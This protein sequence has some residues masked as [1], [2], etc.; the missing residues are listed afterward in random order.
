MTGRHAAGI[1]VTEAAALM[2]DHFVK[3][4][5]DADSQR[6]AWPPG[7]TA[8]LQQHVPAAPAAPAPDGPVCQRRFFRNATAV[9]PAA[10]CCPNLG[11]LRLDTTCCDSITWS[12]PVE[13]TRVA[14]SLAAMRDWTGLRQLMLGCVKPWPHLP[15][16]QFW[17]A[18]GGLTQLTELYVHLPQQPNA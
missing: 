12:L 10:T 14:A 7:S 5:G 9:R 18:V 13:E 3:P 15:G 16:A 6:P 1:P 4:A 17:Q 11:D 8:R 2:S